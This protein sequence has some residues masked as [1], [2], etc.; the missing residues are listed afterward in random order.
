MRSQQ[1][2]F[3]GM[4]VCVCVCVCVCVSIISTVWYHHRSYSFLTTTPTSFSPPLLL[5]SHHHSYSFHTITPT[6][7]SPPLLLISHYHSYSFLTIT[8]THYSPP[9]L[10]ISH[11]HSYFFLTITPTSFSP[12]LPPHSLPL[13]VHRVRGYLPLKV[14]HFIMNLRTTTHAFYLSR[15]VIQFKEEEY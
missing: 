8:P 13:Q 1:T 5:L 11:H 4:G 6:H 2:S 7:S 9:L 14:V 3:R 10:L 15:Y 12:L